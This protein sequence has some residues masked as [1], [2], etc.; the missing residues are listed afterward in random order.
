M[1]H[2]V[3]T[4]SKCGES[5]IVTY[6]MLCAIWKQGYDTINEER[7]L[8]AT[9]STVVTCVCGYHETYDSPMLDWVFTTLFDEF[10][11][12]KVTV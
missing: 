2:I 5:S 9:P 8:Q 6:A 7:K 3:L 1:Y 11:K 12:E 10:V 4:C